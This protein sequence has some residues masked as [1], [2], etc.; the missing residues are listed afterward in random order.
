MTDYPD[1]LYDTARRGEQVRPRP[2][3]MEDLRLRLERLPESH[4]SSPRYRAGDRRAPAE[5]SGWDSPEMSD[6]PQR[7]RLDAIRLTDDRKR[8]I[9]DGDAQGGGHRPGT[10]RPGKTEFPATWD[11]AKIVGVILDVARQPDRTPTRQNWNGRWQARGTRDGVEVVSILD[12]D[13]RIWSSWPLDG[14]PGVVKN[15]KKGTS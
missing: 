12:P 14:G 10:G 4:P 2:Y 7:P 11:D 1:R 13:G 8:H 9:L 5:R 6:H 15:P 3:S